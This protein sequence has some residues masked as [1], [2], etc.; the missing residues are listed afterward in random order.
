M[1]S[2]PNMGYFVTVPSSL[3]GQSLAAALLAFY[4]Q[5]AQNHPNTEGCGGLD[6]DAYYSQSQASSNSAT[7]GG[8]TAGNVSLLI[9]S[10]MKYQVFVDVGSVT[11]PSAVFNFTYRP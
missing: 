9:D 10:S 2:C 8:A 5:T 11:G 3:T 6:I 7:A 1:A 4:F